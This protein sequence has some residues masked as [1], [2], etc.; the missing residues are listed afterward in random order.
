MNHEHWNAMLEHVRG[1]FPEEAC[2]ILGGIEAEVFEV[3]PVTNVLHSPVRYRM[4]PQEQY[5]A[6]RHIDDSGHEIVGI[7]HSHV[8]GPEGPSITDLAEANYP[9]SAYLIW[10]RMYREWKC[11][12]YL[13]SDGRAME[14]PILFRD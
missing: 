1:W 10:S 2:G 9:E 4:D 11:K 8:S 5:N 12:A 3:H 7:F 6:M 13:I 14:I